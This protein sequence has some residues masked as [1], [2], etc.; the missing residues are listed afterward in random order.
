MIAMLPHVYAIAVTAFVTK[1]NLSVRK[2]SWF[3]RYMPEL[4]CVCDCILE[5]TADSNDVAAR[6]TGNGDAETVVAFKTL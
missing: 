4:I 5:S 2:S 6:Q 1:K 3:G